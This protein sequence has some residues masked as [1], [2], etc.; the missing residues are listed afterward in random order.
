MDSIHCCGYYSVKTIQFQFLSKAYQRFSRWKSTQLNWEVWELNHLILEWDCIS[1]Y[2]LITRS[3]YPMS[4][5]HRLCY[6]LLS[7]MS[8]KPNNL[9][10]IKIYQILKLNS[11]LLPHHPNTSRS[12]D[13]T[14]AEIDEIFHNL[15][16]YRIF[17]RLHPVVLRDLCR[18]ACIEFLDKAVFRTYSTIGARFAE[19]SH[20]ISPSKSF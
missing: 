16:N 7:S 10:R 3:H 4:G 11:R 18:H 15:S 14:E 20:F 12:S 5:C 19:R 9:I 2:D 13:R 6:P 1:H 8:S 17:Q